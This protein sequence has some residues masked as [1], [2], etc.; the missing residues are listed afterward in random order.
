MFIGGNA[1]TCSVGRVLK[2]D[3]SCRSGGLKDKILHSN[4]YVC[5]CS[6]PPR[7]ANVRA[8]RVYRASYFKLQ[9]AHL[10]VPRLRPDVQMAIWPSDS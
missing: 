3:V 1:L 4:H 6:I 2:R 8:I 9:V 10:Y 5:I 7:S